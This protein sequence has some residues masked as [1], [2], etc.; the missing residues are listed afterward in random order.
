MKRVRP[1]DRG[2]FSPYGIEE[3]VDREISNHLESRARELEAEGWSS[4]EAMEEARRLFGD[5][6][7]VA[8]E[9]RRIG[10]SHERAEERSAMLEV[11]WQ[12]IRFGTRVFLRNPLF[13]LVAMVTLALGIGANTAVF[14]IVNGVL[15]RPLPFDEPQELVWVQEVNAHNG[16]M[17]VA[18]ANFMDWRQE[19][20]SFAGLAAY[21][22][23]GA[24]ILG[25]DRPVRAQITT[26]SEDFWTVFPVR[27]VA[28]R[29]ASTEDLQRGSPLV[30]VVGDVRLQA[31]GQ[32]AIPAVYFPYTQR[33]YRV[34]YGTG[35]VVEARNG[36]AATLSNTVHTILQ[37]L[38]P[39]VPLQF[40]TLDAQVRDSVADRRF[41]MLILGGFSLTALLLAAVGIYGVVSHTV[42]Q[43]TREMGIRMALGADGKSVRLLVMG[44][45]LRMVLFGLAG[46]VLGSLVLSRT[47]SSL[48]YEV[49]PWDPTTLVLV[50][51][52]LLAT[53]LL[54]SWIPARSGTRVD[55]VR[56]MRVE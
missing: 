29:M 10:R 48:L 12:D 2:I 31:L 39:D 24:T 28:G 5:C 18:W 8:G 44:G 32:E 56:S 26:V 22:S 55:P 25:G 50:V 49:S 52:A 21:G 37:R 45:A 47:M 42:A 1:G 51:L 36:D 19:S 35:V 30:G 15:L 11:L 20:G 34:A 16:P 43:R 3:D 13:T 7:Q 17:S 6:D 54:A 4:S 14:S 38:D 40:R 9:C 27:P 41:V 46:G 23:T 33:P 53:A